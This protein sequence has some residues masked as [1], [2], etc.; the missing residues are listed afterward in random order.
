TRCSRRRSASRQS[1]RYSGGGRAPAELKEAERGRPPSLGRVV[2][3][4]GGGA[5]AMDV[6]RVAK[7]LGA[8]EAVL[9]FRRDRP[10]LKAPP[11]EA[12]EAFAEG[13]K[14]RWLSVASRFGANGVTI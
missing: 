8:E 11:A 1:A 14:I 9:I 12:E 3:V 5:T 13:V 2:G 10:H 7:R 6:A 4:I